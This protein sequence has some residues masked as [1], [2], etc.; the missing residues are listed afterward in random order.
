MT[1][2]VLL[3]AAACLHHA[4]CWRPL[5]LLTVLSGLLEHWGGACAAT[6]GKLAM[7]SKQGQMCKASGIAAM[8]A[9]LQPLQP[10]LP[11][12]GDGTRS[13]KHASV[14]CGL[15]RCSPVHAAAAA[16]SQGCAWRRSRGLA[17]LCCRAGDACDPVRPT[18]TAHMRPTSTQPGTTVSSDG[19]MHRAAWN[20]E[21]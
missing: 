3:S 13:G 18:V 4:R 6:L 8:A 1:R 16:A 2:P 7:H 15:P 21:L 12:T 9:Q 20:S 5:L 10:P 14:R 19:C 11:W 17:R